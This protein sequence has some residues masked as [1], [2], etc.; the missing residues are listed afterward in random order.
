MER[1]HGKHD[2]KMNLFLNQACFLLCCLTYVLLY[3]NCMHPIARNV[4]HKDQNDF[5]LLPENKCDFQRV[6]HLKQISTRFSR[7]HQ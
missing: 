3:L 5:E 6:K 4:P 2:C 7:L 1:K